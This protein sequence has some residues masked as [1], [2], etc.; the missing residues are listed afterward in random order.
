[1]DEYLLQNYWADKARG[2][3]PFKAFKKLK[4]F[5]FG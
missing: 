5:K 4:P 2:E 1:M 3:Y